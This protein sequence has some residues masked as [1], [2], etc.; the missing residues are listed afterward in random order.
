M[1]NTYR[2]EAFGAQEKFQA[3]LERGDKILVYRNEDLSHP[4]RGRLMFLPSAEAPKPDSHAPDTEACGLGWRYTLQS[5]ETTLDNFAFVPPTPSEM[6]LDLKPSKLKK[7]VAARLSLGEF[8]VKAENIDSRRGGFW[9]YGMRKSNG[10]CVTIRSW[11]S[12][13][14]LS[15]PTKTP[16]FDEDA[17]GIWVTH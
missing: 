17:R 12:M 6:H 9:A 11:Y 3:W 4:D 5:V 16:K 1:S 15:D 14:D 10:E 2:V 8:L 7:L 13:K